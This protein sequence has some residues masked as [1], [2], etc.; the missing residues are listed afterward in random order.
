MRTTTTGTRIR[1][2]VRDDYFVVD[3]VEYKVLQVH[4]TKGDNLTTVDVVDVDGRPSALVLP[5]HLAIAVTREDGL[6]GAPTHVVVDLLDGY[7]FYRDIHDGAFTE[8]TAWAFAVQ[9]NKVSTRPTYQVY[10]LS[11]VFMAPDG[12]DEEN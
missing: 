6:L 5:G 2:L 3:S 1:D 4:N 9:R 7:T 12:W 11:R 8:K 10:A